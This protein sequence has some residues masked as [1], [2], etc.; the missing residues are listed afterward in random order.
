MTTLP[1]SNAFPPSPFLTLPS[2]AP[3]LAQPLYSLPTNANPHLYP[4]PLSLSLLLPSP[5]T[6]PPFLT[7]DPPIP[8]M[9]RNKPATLPPPT[10][11]AVTTTKRTQKPES[12]SISC[13]AA[14]RAAER[15]VGRS[16]GWVG[17]EKE[18]EL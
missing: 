3:P 2:A 6:N 10:S 16:D 8:P 17:E 7:D 13:W 9:A 4:T 15:R 11:K 18:E 12:S 14:D 5:L 1:Y